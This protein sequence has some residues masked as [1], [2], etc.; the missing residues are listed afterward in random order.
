MK[1]QRNN[2]DERTAKYD[3][4]HPEKKANLSPGKVVEPKISGQ[5]MGNQKFK[6]KS[7]SRE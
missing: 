7:Q 1:K 6:G 4:T 2:S 3:K 5:E